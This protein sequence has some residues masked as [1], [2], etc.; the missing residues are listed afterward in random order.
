MA[1]Q[2]ILGRITQLAR[3]NINAL[4]DSAEDPQMMLDQMIR[5]YTESIREAEESVAQTIGNLR[6]MEEDSREAAE[7][8]KDWGSKAA[9]ASARGDAM[10]AS[11]ST[12]EAERF[13]GL[14]RVALA[15]QLD[16]E[17]RV[18]SMGPTIEQQRD[19]VE[20]L[21]AGL[22]GM[23][24]KL[25]ELRSKRDELVARS[26]VA[27]AQQQVQEAV[28]GIDMA[29]PTSELSRFEDRIRREEAQARGQAELAASSM[30]AQFDTLDDMGDDA[31]V[32][33][34]LAALKGGR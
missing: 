17:Q 7:A 3:A 31:E 21:K 16:F 5:D 28:K 27:T 6:L 30:Q 19:V 26:R 8:A 14:A 11:G 9:A 33:S 22:E 29:D 15:K 24:G 23:R 2:S 12:T 34:R 18:Q 13:N 25:E 20:K 10:T 4:L 1:Q 32:E